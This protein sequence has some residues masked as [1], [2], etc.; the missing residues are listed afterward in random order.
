MFT[1]ILT[2]IGVVVIVLALYR[3]ITDTS[4]R[5][6]TGPLRYNRGPLCSFMAPA[7]QATEPATAVQQA[8]QFD[9]SICEDTGRVAQEINSSNGMRTVHVPCS[10]GE[11]VGL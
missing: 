11:R 8:P 5:G 2:A 9:C 7:A 10:C 1:N 3:V 4:A 6:T